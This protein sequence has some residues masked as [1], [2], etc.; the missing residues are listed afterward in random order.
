MPH[1]IC[2][3][4]GIFWR[5]GTSSRPAGWRLSRSLTATG[6]RPRGIAENP[7][8]EICH[9][10]CATGGGARALVSK[11]CD[12]REALSEIQTLHLSSYLPTSIHPPPRPLYA[13]GGAY[14]PAVC[15]GIR[16]RSSSPAL[17]FGVFPSVSLARSFYIIHPTSTVV[18]LYN[19]VAP[20]VSNRRK[21][22]RA[23]VSDGNPEL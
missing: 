15:I 1:Q 6:V 23:R 2:K 13:Y 11:E 21:R 9:P 16:S 18:L 8:R 22:E 19:L 14:Y 10:S 7:S 5:N 17:L 20:D 12:A 3:A 4:R